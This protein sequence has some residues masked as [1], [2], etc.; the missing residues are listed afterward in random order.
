VQQKSNSWL[1]L[2]FSKYSQFKKNT[3]LGHPFFFAKLILTER[4]RHPKM[5]F[6]LDVVHNLPAKLPQKSWM[7]KCRP[8]L[9][10]VIH[11]PQNGVGSVCGL[12]FPSPWTLH[13]PCSTL[14][15]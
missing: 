5:I 2:S 11:K 8:D 9:Y 6:Q 7:K 10:I 1:K 14:E 12:K 15:W 3:L 13:A 4:R